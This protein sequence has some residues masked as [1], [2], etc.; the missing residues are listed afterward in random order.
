M[1]DEEMASI[2]PPGTLLRA[3][4]TVLSV[5]VCVALSFM[6]GVALAAGSAPAA[7]TSSQARQGALRA[8]VATL[9]PALDEYVVFIVSSEE[10]KHFLLAAMNGFRAAIGLG[11]MEADTIFVVSGPDSEAF[12]RRM[13]FEISG[14]R[15]SPLPEVRVE[16]LGER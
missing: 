7:D 15:G 1:L 2:A 13:I 6:A 10:K 11:A 5:P 9:D 14:A 3:L 8:P 12:A 4:F 16:D